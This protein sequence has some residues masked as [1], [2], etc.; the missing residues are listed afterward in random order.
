MNDPTVFI[1]IPNWNGLKHLSYSLP[2]LARTTYPNFQAVLVDDDS[3]DGSI[4]FVKRNYPFIKIIQN[5]INKGFAGTVNE[6]IKFALD[7]GADYIAVFNS[8]IQVLPGWIEPA[9]DIF[10]ERA[11]VGLVGYTEIPPER[12]EIFYR[13]EVLKGKVGYEEVKHLR[14]CLFICPVEV[15]RHIGLFDEGYYMYNEDNDFFYRLSWAGYKILQTNIPVWHFSEGSIERKFRATWFA[16]RNSI[17]FAIKNENIIRIFRM[18]LALIYH[19]CNPFLTRKPDDSVLK[20]MRRYDIF[21]TIILIVASICWNMIHLIQTLKSH[22]KTYRQIKRPT[23]RIKIAINTLSVQGGGGVSNFLNL[24]PSLSRIDNCNEY[25]VFISDR[26]R[27]ILDTIPDSFKTVTIHYIPPS[28]FLRV[29]WEQIVFPFYLLFYKIDILYTVGNMTTLL[30]PCRVVLLMDNPTP[31]SHLNNGWTKKELLRIKLIKYLGLLSAKRADKVRFVS[32]NSKRIL[33]EELNLPVAKCETI[34]HGCDINYNG[35]GNDFIEDVKLKNNYILTVA[36]PAPY[37]NLQQLIK[38]F[39]VLVK[40]YNYHGNLV[41]VGDLFYSNYVK[42]LRLLVSELNLD[43]RIIFT[44]KVEHKKIKYFYT[45]AD[46]F[47]LPSIAETFGMPITEAMSCG[48]P[49]E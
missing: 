24:I 1:I 35:A 49:V 4:D 13:T 3:T 37:K 45:H 42:I 7:Q 6:G 9:I 34:Y 25:I 36:I 10:L 48:V 26:Q 20:R 19:G 33:V 47:V 8:D 15:F 39:D 18:V 46:L 43:E 12:E 27:E 17:R 29:A 14:G 40:K 31:Y 30:A 11:D 22:Y 38:A 2:S 32:D 28:P 23:E 16:Y 41:I 21:T 5:N 44:G